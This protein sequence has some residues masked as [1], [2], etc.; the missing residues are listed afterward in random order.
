MQV[1][2]QLKSYEK[3]AFSLTLTAPVEDWRAAMKQ[4][5]EKV[6]ENGHVAWP[7]SG[8]YA[9]IEKML[10]D[11]DKTHWDVLRREDQICALGQ[12]LPTEK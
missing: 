5:E 12:S 3:V 8:L 7:L 11:L 2:A 10:G 9:S 1:K 4:L 6:K